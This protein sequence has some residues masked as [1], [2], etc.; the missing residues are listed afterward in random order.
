M[1]DVVR[2]LDALKSPTNVRGISIIRQSDN[3][4]QPYAT[5]TL[6]I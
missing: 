6:L 3:T 5:S 2:R 1:T 4:P